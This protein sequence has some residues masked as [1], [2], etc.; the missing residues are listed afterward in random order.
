MG[1]FTFICGIAILVLV[2]D[3]RGRVQKLE[4]LIKG[5]A[6]QGTPEPS[7]YQPSSPRPEAQQSAP[8]FSQPA[9]VPA[10]QRPTA[11]DRF[12]EWLKEDWLLK[13][14]AMFLLMGFGWFATYAFLNN[15]IGPM[16]RI[17]LGIIAGALFI[18][19]GW[20]RIK[21]YI[22]QGGVFLVLGS[23]TILLTIFA[24][25]E[26]YDFFTPF[27]ALAVMFLS[28]A[29]VAL[30]SVKYDNRA[31]ALASLIL[32][33]IAP[34]LA[35]A[36]SP[37]YVGLYSYL[38][39]VILGAIW[40]VALTGGRELTTAALVLVA[41]YSLPH[42]FSFTSADKGTLLLFAYAFA[43]V[44]FLTNT[45]G[46]LKP[47]DKEIV[48]D[49][50]TAAGN[51][52]FLLVWIMTAAQ[53]EWKSLIIAAWTIVFAGGGFLIFR[54]TQRREPFYVYAGVGIAML[55]AATSAELKGATLTIAYA[56]ES[57][58]VALIAY[59]ILRDIKIAE[60]TSL[61]LIGPVILSFGSI[62]SR[63]WATSVI[64]KDFFVLLILGA[65]L[66]GLG[67]FFL[68]RVG[69]TE[70]KEPRQLN[71]I[72][73]IAGSAYVYALLWLSLHAVLR[74]DDAAVMIALAIYTVAGLIAYFH[75]LANEKRGL[76]VYGGTLVGLVVGRLLLVD[77][78]RMELAGRI[79]TFFLIGA[80]LVS[81]AFLGRK[82]QVKT[83]PD[84]A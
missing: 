2:L 54:I 60:R 73:L 75:G 48:P 52:L 26:I 71:A 50:V 9:V 80:L 78:W 66:L 59:A 3:L 57:G 43:A 30:A 12:V 61:L 20:W 65:T 5:G 37:N 24:A 22:H 16:G 28:A 51:G 10:Q 79:V 64:H 49:L 4:R 81:T 77:V 19:L 56:I 47:R 44:F 7:Y 46:I 6:T 72:L 68:R 62:T 1:F 29:F 39:V 21:K 32:A 25:R 31:L 70:D 36:P 53:D 84:N 63:A 38:F 15:W 13:L 40:I 27:S 34:L 41:F 18:L 17:A 67:S 42:L 76:R 23:T 69:E 45:A 83:I 14:G 33:G 82:K 58:I 74:N 11:S 35:G 8:Q 55:A